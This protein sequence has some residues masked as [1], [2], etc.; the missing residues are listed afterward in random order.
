MTDV[1]KYL[2]QST[3]GIFPSQKEG[4]PLSLLEMMAYNLP[5]I[6]S[7]I[8]ELTS[9]IGHKQEGL[10]FELDNIDDLKSKIEFAMKNKD[11]MI[12]YGKNAR[13]KVMKICMENEPIK[14]HDQFYRVI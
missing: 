14:F 10:V 5:I 9:I 13:L 2:N 3:I 11:K 6:V 12:Q 8:E 7:N 4:L 1:K